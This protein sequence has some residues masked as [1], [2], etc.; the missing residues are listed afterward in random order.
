MNRNLFQMSGKQI[1]VTGGGSGIGKEVALQLASQGAEV[2]IISR[3][4][5]QL[6]K[7]AETHPDQLFPVAADV[8]R[9]EDVERVMGEVNKRFSTIDVLINAA[10]SVR[11]V[12][13]RDSL[14]DA[15][16]NWQQD[17]GNNLTTSFFM[18]LACAPLLTRPGGRIINISSIAA[19]TGGRRAGAMSYAAAKSG[20]IGLTFGLA[21]E[22]SP[23]GITANVIAP[24][25]IA[26]T[27]FTGH[28]PQEAI[29]SIVAQTPVGR[30]GHVRD[31]AAAIQ[32]LASD[33]SSFITGEVLH[34]NGGWIFG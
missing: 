25:L 11:G 22:L 16:E 20:L 12:S 33:E 23:E 26:D 3:T 28:W 30:P 31:V 34:V 19:F 18:S 9:R 15:E 5:E 6:Q 4:E 13:T 21:R 32:F 27:D 1:V 8:S 7:V 24:G 10:G 14:T 2:V 17:I 29:D